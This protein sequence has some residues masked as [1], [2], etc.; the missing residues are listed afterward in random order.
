MRFIQS[1][2]IIFRAPTARRF[3]HIVVFKPISCCCLHPFIKRAFILFKHQQIFEF[4]DRSLDFRSLVRLF[5]QLLV[6]RFQLVDQAFSLRFPPC[7]FAQSPLLRY[8][9]NQLD[10]S[11]VQI[12]MR[13]G[14]VRM[15]SEMWED[16]AF[17]IVTSTLVPFK[18]FGR[19]NRIQSSTPRVCPA[20]FAQRWRPIEAFLLGGIKWPSESA[21]FEVQQELLS[22]SFVLR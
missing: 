19:G 21:T 10:F 22:G 12:I 1:C 11:L 5:H 16:L 2:P 3:R 13:R 8:F 17:A 7:T 14:V 20:K 18:L 4:S 6:Q 9:L 15:S